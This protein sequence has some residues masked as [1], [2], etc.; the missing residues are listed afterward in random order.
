MPPRIQLQSLKYS[1]QIALGP[2]SQ[3]IQDPISRFLKEF[4]L[5]VN[6]E[7]IGTAGSQYSRGRILTPVPVW[8]T[9][10]GVEQS[11]VTCNSMSYYGHPGG[12]FARRAVREHLFMRVINHQKAPYHIGNSGSNGTSASR[13]L[14]GLLK[15]A[16]GASNLHRLKIQSGQND[17]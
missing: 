15:S 9:C 17:K 11:T 3:I 13:S 4:Q 2:S 6:R 10:P 1:W 5:T 7:R 8:S 14:Q 12:V 16:F